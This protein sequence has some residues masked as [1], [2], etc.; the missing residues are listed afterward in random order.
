MKTLTT[1]LTC[2]LAIAGV[3]KADDWGT[4]KGKIVLKGDVPDKVMLHAKGE[5][6]VKDGEVCAEIDVYKDDLVIDKET[7]GIA[8]VF[9]YLPKAPKKINKDLVKTEARLVLDQKNCIFK[10][11]AMVVQAGQTVEVLNSDA[12]AHNTHTYPLKNQAVNVLVSP[13]TALGAGTEVPTTIR[14]IVPHE[15]KC[16]IHPWMKALWL[17]VDHPYAAAT[18]EKGEFEIKGL[19]V[20]E[21][22]FRIWHERTGYL[23][24][25]FVVTVKAGDENVAKPLEYELSK[26]EE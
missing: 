1:I 26:F 13:N 16:D 3:A 8:N 20:G 10:P 18:N 22:E 21:H 24:K 23:E 7:K 11:H 5:S 2:M 19:P 14:E 4:L 9:I 12:V 15:V 6:S 17:V 25:K